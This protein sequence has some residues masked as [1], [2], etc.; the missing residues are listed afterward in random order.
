MLAMFE[1]LKAMSYVTR[2]V[3]GHK[4]GLDMII[5]NEFFQRGVGLLSPTGFGQSRT[6]IRKQVTHG[7]NFNVG[8]IL[9]TKGCPK[10]ADSISNDTHTNLAVRDLL[11]SFGS[12]GIQRY[13]VETRDCLWLSYRRSPQT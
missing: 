2:R 12:T 5:L 3:R 4:Y 7:H 9:K 8:M 11:P 6:P 13:F 10:L 1:Y